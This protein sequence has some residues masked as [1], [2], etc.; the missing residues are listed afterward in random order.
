MKYLHS[1]QVRFDEITYT[2]AGEVI[3]CT[4]NGQSDTFDFTGFPE[5]K[6]EEI[7]TTLPE[8]PIIEAYREGGILHAVLLKSI[9]S[10]ATEAERY[11]D[12]VV[13]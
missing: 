2:F 8:K 11:P 13:V 10:E 4:I 12:W 3:T 9:T 1:P 7:E 5:G 6:L